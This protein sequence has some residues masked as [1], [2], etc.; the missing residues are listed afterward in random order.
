[1]ALY[2]T[3]N[4]EFKAHLT[5]STE[6]LR[7]ILCTLQGRY[8]WTRCQRDVFFQTRSGR[9]KLREEFEQGESVAAQLIPYLREDVNTARQSCYTVVPLPDGQATCQLLEEILGLRGIVEKERELWLLFDDTVRVHI[10]T[11]K[12]LGLFVE[13]EAVIGMNPHPDEADSAPTSAAEQKQRAEFLMQALNI[14]QADLCAKAYI[15]MLEQ[16]DE[17]AGPAS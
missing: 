9:L 4:I 15:D 3:G 10:D 12:G 2:P 8:V 7:Q 6:S 1:M 11:V 13:V 16:G 5:C 17:S 14:R